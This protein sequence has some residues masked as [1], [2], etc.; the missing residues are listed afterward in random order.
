MFIIFNIIE[1]GGLVEMDYCTGLENQRTVK[2][3][4]SSNLTPSSIY[5]ELAESGLLQQFAKLQDVK[6]PRVRIPYS[7][8][9][10]F[11]RLR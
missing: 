8:Q 1:H 5:R 2:G 11:S 4:V 7:L 6:V 3:S 9:V 10:T